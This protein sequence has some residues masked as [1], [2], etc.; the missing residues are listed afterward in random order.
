MPPGNQLQP[1]LC[2]GAGILPGVVQQY[3]RHL[4][5]ALG[6]APNPD[7]RGDLLRQY[8][9]PLKK[10]CL[11][12]QGGLQHKLAQIHPG[13][14]QICLLTV[15]T[16]QLQ[17][18]LHQ[19]AH[20]PGHSQDALLK[21]FPAGLLVFPTLQQLRV[22]DDHRQ[23]RFQLMGGIRQKLL[24]LLP[25][26]VHRADGPPGQKQAQPQKTG[27]AQKP[28]QNRVF[29]EIAQGGALTGQI[30]KHQCGALLAGKAGKAKVLLLQ[31]PVFPLLC[32]LHHGLQHALLR[33]LIETS[34][35]IHNS[36][37]GIQIEDKIGQLHLLP[38]IVGKSVVPG[39][40]GQRAHG[41][42]GGLLQIIPGEA[43]KQPQNHNQQHR[44]HGHVDDHKFYPQLSDQSSATSMV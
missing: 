22:G 8:Q 7:S 4:L 6:I 37:L 11:H 19:R 29:Q 18:L 34:G 39:R 1:N 24:L 40:H 15:G 42:E 10:Q 14:G 33:Q 30:H 41:L 31:H 21:C 43:V 5:Q 12:G 3:F 25:R 44:Q 2:A 16:G 23:G 32:H 27:K 35:G 17:H 20:L 38:A 28:H 36:A 9:P 26:R 13:E